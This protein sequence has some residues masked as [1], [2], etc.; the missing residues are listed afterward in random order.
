MASVHIF[1]VVCPRV[2]HGGATLS[3]NG[4]ITRQCRLGRRSLAVRSVQPLW[5]ADH[6][7]AKP[8]SC[9]TISPQPLI[10]RPTDANGSSDS[11]HC[12]QRADYR[13]LS[14]TRQDRPPRSCHQEDYRPDYPPIF[15]IH[16]IRGNDARRPSKLCPFVNK[17][18]IIR[19]KRTSR[20]VGDTLPPLR[21]SY[22]SATKKGTH[23]RGSWPQRLSAHRENVGLPPTRADG[24]QN[25]KVSPPN[26]RQDDHQVK[27]SLASQPPSDS[28]NTS[29]LSPKTHIT[30]GDRQNRTLSTVPRVTNEGCLRRAS[31]SVKSPC[32]PSGIFLLF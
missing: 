32:A 2:V 18:R 20:Y 27:H 12:P 11:A 14:K 30:A 15:A 9:P 26:Q 3:T 25:S 24:R 29:V 8:V 28:R 5:H 21:D 13:Q 23:S 7:E 4:N 19:R 16:H 17:I 31:Q 6:P 10:L 22:G 1:G